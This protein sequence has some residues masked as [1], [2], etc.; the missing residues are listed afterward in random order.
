MDA[1]ATSLARIGRPLLATAVGLVVI[2]AVVDALSLPGPVVLWTF[3][4]LAFLVTLAT[5]GLLLAR[6]RPLAG[7][8]A[9]LAGGS[10]L[11]GLAWRTAPAGIVW[12]LLFL[13]GAALV[14]RGT[15]ADTVSPRSWAIV[16]PRLVVGWAFADNG[17][18]DMVWVPGGGGFLTAATAAAKRDPAFLD[19]GY[20]PFLQGLVLP[21][22]DTFAGLFL[23]GELVFGLLLALGL[24]SAIAASG[25]MWLSANI[26]LEKS[27]MSH[28]AYVDKTYFAVELFCLVVGAGFVYGVDAS[29]QRY[30]PRWA[31]RW[32]AGGPQPAI[33][34]G[35][36]AV[37]VP[38]RAPGGAG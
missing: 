23:S 17:I 25:A 35:G 11:V 8:G 15:A 26:I 7:I 38:A 28:G 6:S 5:G 32:F 30:L 20:Q 24:F 22:P 16:I 12:S 14:V 2:V 3:A 36:P 37:T 21:R 34:A 33:G 13:A 18:N 27:F 9:I 31:V 29:L 1:F 4:S 10:I 19:G